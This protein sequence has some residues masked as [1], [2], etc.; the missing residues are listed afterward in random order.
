VALTPASWRVFSRRYLIAFVAALVA[1][2][3]SVVVLNTKVNDTLAATK[4]LGGLTFPEG[5]AEGGNYLIIGSDSR[6]FVQDAAQAQA[7]GNAQDQGGQRADVMM[8]LHVDP[9]TKTNYLVSFP[10]DLLVNDPADPGH[11]VQIN[12][13]LN[14]GPQAVID[15]MKKDFDVNINHYVQVDFAAFIGVVDAIGKIGVYFPYPSRDTYTGL[16]VIAGCSQL[17][18]NN[19]LAYVRSRH[20]QELRNGRWQ[21]ASPLGDIDR[22]SRQQDFIRKLASQ[23]S[24]KAGQNPLDAID[25]AK[26]VVPKLHVDDQLSNAN[27]LRLVKTFRNVDPEQPGALEMHTLPWNESRSQPGRLEVKQPDAE[28][29]LATLRTFGGTPAAQKKV[30]PS[31]VVVS[32]ANGSD[33]AGEAGRSLAALQLNGFGPGDAVNASPTTETLVRYQPGKLAQAELV[34]QYLGGAGTLIEDGTVK[35]ADVVVVIGADWRGVHA[36]GKKASVSSTSTTTAPKTSTTTAKGS[37][38]VAPVSAGC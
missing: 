35:D 1:V 25:I 16:N 7:F 14:D 37:A 11:T 21:D 29:V 15:L 13:V 8:V 18:G 10:R 22:I 27:I 4:R 31:D 28:A 36:K 3:S 38:P 34:S 5:P 30:R 6:A 2:V 19:A 17:D 12:G 9:E 23:A 33:Q 24:A 26:A 32:V 20:M